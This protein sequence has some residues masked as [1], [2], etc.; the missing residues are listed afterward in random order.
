MAVTINTDK[1]RAEFFESI[2][3]SHEGYVCI[4]AARA[5]SRHFN[6]TYFEWPKDI[7]KMMKHINEVSGGHNVWFCAQ[8][9]DEPKRVKENVGLCYAL[10]ADLDT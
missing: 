2:F 10:W 6:E 4:A 7:A 9:L 5:T 1:L 3:G 8:L